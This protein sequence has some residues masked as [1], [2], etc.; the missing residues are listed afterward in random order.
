M[1]HY[2]VS[3]FDSAAEAYGRVFTVTSKG[4]AVRSFRD[5]LN[6]ND[7]NNPMFR[8]YAQFNL[9]CVGEFDDSDGSVLS[10]P[11]PELLLTGV[12]AKEA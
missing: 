4:L 8:H 2:F 10:Y 7:E 3:V 1:K 6:R 5:E 11:C 9:F 12:L